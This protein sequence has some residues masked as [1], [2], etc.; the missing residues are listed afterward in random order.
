MMLESFVDTQKYSVMKSM[1]DTFRKYLTFKKDSTELLY[2]ILRQITNEHVA[3]NRGKGVRDAMVEIH[4][5]D[6]LE[7]AKQINIRDVK[8]FYESNCSNL[9]TTN[10]ILTA[11]DNTSNYGLN[12]KSHEKVN[13]LKQFHI[14]K[15]L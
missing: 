11:D 7:R 14:V 9:T 8:P 4:E 13:V 6:F 5:S 15:Y 1:R 10:T 12:L 3:F 2:Y